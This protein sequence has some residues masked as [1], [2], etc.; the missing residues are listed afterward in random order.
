VLGH[1]HERRRRIVTA[2]AVVLD[3]PA[4]SRAAL[5]SL[6]LSRRTP[7]SS[8]RPARETRTPTR[9]CSPAAIE[10]DARPKTTVEAAREPA[11]R[12]GAV[13]LVWPQQPPTVPEGQ[14]S[15]SGMN[16]PAMASRVDTTRTP[17]KASVGGGGDVEGGDVEGGIVAGG[18]VE[19]GVVAGGVVGAGDEGVGSTVAVTFTRVEGTSP[20]GAKMVPAGG[21]M[22]LSVRSTMSP[23]S[24]LNAHVGEPLVCLRP[25]RS[26]PCTAILGLKVKVFRWFG[27]R[28]WAGLAATTKYW[29]A[30]S[31]RTITS[32]IA[33]MVLPACVLQEVITPPPAGTA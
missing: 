28:S 20:N 15:F 6:P 19:G 31:G 32:F 27:K 10:N 11:R 8:R 22:P 1:G 16:L 18:V 9:A 5:L 7:P 24:A 21:S 26:P 13:S 23:A 30:A 3:R 14:L 4:P 2:A 25:S 12:R 33:P 29:F 17:A